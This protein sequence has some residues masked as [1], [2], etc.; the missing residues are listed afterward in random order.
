V[1]YFLISVLCLLAYPVFAQTVTLGWD[2]SPTT[3][4]VVTGYKIYYQATP[5]ISDQWDGSGATEGSSPIDAGDVLTYDLT[6]LTDDVVYYFTITA[7][8]A[9]G[10]E[11]AYSNV[12][13]SDPNGNTV[14]HIGGH[15]VRLFNPMD[16]NAS[17]GSVSF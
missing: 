5:Y 7:Y 17:K 2:A 15:G 1:R 11:S 4:P 10:N 16:A 6:D 8:D 9:D 3:D 12:V 14:L 13:Y